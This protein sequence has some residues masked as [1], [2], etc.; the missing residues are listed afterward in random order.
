MK[1]FSKFGKKCT[2]MKCQL[3]GLERFL[4]NRCV[5]TVNL[6]I[7]LYRILFFADESCIGQ[8]TGLPVS[9]FSLVDFSCHNLFMNME[10]I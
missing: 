7:R 9:W 1:K 2:A 8:L 5:S 10:N 6:D 4:S 3:F